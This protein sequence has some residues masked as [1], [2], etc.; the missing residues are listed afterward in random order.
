MRA[1][2]WRLRRDSRRSRWVVVDE[3]GKVIG[4]RPTKAACLTHA[5][6]LAKRAATQRRPVSLRVHA[7]DG[8]VAEERT[9][10]RSADP[11]RSPG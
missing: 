3:H 1:R 11:T 4:S 2:T 9:Y 8:T 5:T 7:A 10:P 6:A